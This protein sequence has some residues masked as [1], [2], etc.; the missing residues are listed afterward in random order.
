MFKVD[1]TTYSLATMLATNADDPEL[2]AWLLSATAGDVFT[3]GE[4]CT[5][6]EVA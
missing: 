2:C 4:G 5:C 6:V 1:G 3:D